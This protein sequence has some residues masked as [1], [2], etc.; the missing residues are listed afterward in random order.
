MNAENNREVKSAVRAL[1]ILEFL[2]RADKSV[3]L[4]TVVA[5]LGYPKSSTFNLLATLVA[6]AYV[7]RDET[8]SYRIHEAFRNGPGWVNGGE[9]H[10]IALAQPIMNAMRDSEGET[11][12]LGARRKD[13]RIK[14]LAKSVSHQAVRF[15]S[16]LEGSDPAYCTAMGRMLLA[17]W[18]SD[19]VSSYL[20]KERIVPHTEKTI[21][22]RVQ[23]RRI[24]DMAREAGFAI[25]DE[26]AVAG[27]S[28]VAAPIFDA[29]GD[30]IAALNIATISSR[31]AA[32]RQRLIDAVVGHAA[33]LSRRLGYKSTTLEEQ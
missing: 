11:V 4:K 21:I 31:F 8:E 28:G 29:S 13:G 15:D 32:C 5:E 23:I 25:C 1:E 16:G 33:E 22:D 7:V 18:R 10:L 30:V 20:A 9:A 26:E 14:V 27:G 24:I 6:R 2:A 3:T 12:F 17:H 19:K